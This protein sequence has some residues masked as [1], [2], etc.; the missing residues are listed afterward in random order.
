[1]LNIKLFASSEHSDGNWLGY[2]VP[3]I[4]WKYEFFDRKCNKNE[5]ILN[6]IFT[7]VATTAR[8]T[9]LTIYSCKISRLIG[10]IWFSTDVICSEQI[11]DNL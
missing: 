8:F 7:L 6:L 1:M 10:S 9:F 2:I 5:I 3:N 4:H 11:V